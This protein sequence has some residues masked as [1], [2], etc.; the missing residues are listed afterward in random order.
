MLPRRDVSDLGRAHRLSMLRR[1]TAP[2]ELRDR[3]RA[4]LEARGEVETV[5]LLGVS[6]HTLTRLLA[7][8]GVRRGTLA[9]VERSF[10]RLDRQPGGLIL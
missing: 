2:A 8:L 3:V 1:Y 9:I 4:L 5:D 6:R 7:G 10:E